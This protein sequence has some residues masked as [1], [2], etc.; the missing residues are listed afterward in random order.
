MGFI[1]NG[2]IKSVID[3]VTRVFDIFFS[4]TLGILG[5]NLNVFE[6]VFPLV[7]SLNVGIITIALGIAFYIFIYQIWKNLSPTTVNDAESPLSLLASFSTTIIVIIIYRPLLNILLSFTTGSLTIL[8]SSKLTKILEKGLAT[9]M[10]DTFL[11]SLTTKVYFSTKSKFFIIKKLAEVGNKAGNAASDVF[12]AATAKDMPQRIAAI[13]LVAYIYSKLYKIMKIIIRTYVGVGILTYLAPLPLATRASKTTKGYA[14]NFIQIY[15]EHLVSILL[16]CWFLRIVFDGFG[17]IDF[18]NLKKMSYSMSGITS[19]LRN[20]TYATYFDKTYELFATVFIWV[21]MIGAFIDY[22]VNLNVYIERISGIGG[23]SMVPNSSHPSN[24]MK[25]SPISRVVT[26]AMGTAA[27]LAIGV[28][29]QA[30]KSMAG[31]K[32]G[33]KLEKDFEERNGIFSKVPKNEESSD[34]DT[35]SSSERS[36]AATGKKPKNDAAMGG[37]NGSKPNGKNKKN[38]MEPFSPAADNSKQAGMYSLLHKPL[39]GKDAKKQMAAAMKGKDGFMDPYGEGKEYL[40]KLKNGKSKEDQKKLDNSLVFDAG[41]DGMQIMSDIE[42]DGKGK[43]TATMN[44]EDI[45]LFNEDAQASAT[46]NLDASVDIGGQTMS[47]DSSKCPTF[48][49]MMGGITFDE[50][51]IVSS[52]SSS[53]ASTG[54]VGNSSSSGMNTSSETVFRGGSENDVLG[55]ESMGASGNGSNHT[56]NSKSSVD[57]INSRIYNPGSSQTYDDFTVGND[58]GSSSGGPLES[59]K[60]GP[61][62][63]NDKDVNTDQSDI[64]F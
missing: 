45:E 28:P 9:T 48:H 31:K 63:S 8:Q 36:G 2:I 57:D 62:P 14:T 46:G 22:A 20:W 61:K 6:K 17:A 25:E 33:E 12:D 50:S 24:P 4:A 44:G 11:D 52:G 53:G 26:G 59:S 3:I 19:A 43:I 7:K 13:I 10:Y 56:P 18:S 60:S 47:Y 51:D 58:T 21:L 32:V 38:P 54:T 15:I 1:I 30:M 27:G 37:N 42:S 39:S 5:V 29:L 41:K 40:D 49:K 55:N 34:S 35:S 16:N 23:L 64:E